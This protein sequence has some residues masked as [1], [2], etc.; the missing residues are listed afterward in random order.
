MTNKTL[1]ALI[2][3]IIVAVSRLIPHPPN[4]TPVLSI[5]LFSGAFFKKS[6]VA[7][8]VSIIGLSISNAVLGFYSISIIVTAIMTALTFLGIFLK[9]NP[10]R[11]NIFSYSL[12]SSFLF[13]IIS[14][15]FVW[16]S[17]GLYS[18]NLDGLITCYTMALPF[19]Q[20]SLIST[21]IYSFALFE[22]ARMLSLA[23]TSKS[24]QA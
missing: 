15:F 24:I 23:S 16:T 9:N 12:G 20:N 6:W 7:V 8:F 13:F 5:A 19:F 3:I 17:S 2:L 10:S 18:K 22:G 11:L 1:L 14:N 4:F 21:L